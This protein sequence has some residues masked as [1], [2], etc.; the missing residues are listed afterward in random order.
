MFAAADP[1]ARVALAEAIWLG[2]LQRD[3]DDRLL[4]VVARMR[5]DDLP[6][7]RFLGSLAALLTA[8]SEDWPGAGRGGPRRP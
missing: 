6:A 7:V 3:R 4:E 1:V 5:R 2:M 8:A